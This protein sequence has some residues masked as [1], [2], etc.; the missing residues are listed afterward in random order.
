MRAT[1]SLLAL[2]ALLLAAGCGGGEAQDPPAATAEAEPTEYVFAPGDRI[3]VELTMYDGED[4][5]RTPFFS[6]YRPSIEF[7][8][9][10]PAVECGAHLPVDL[11][12]F[13]PGET[14]TIVLECGSEVAVPVDDPGFA[15]VEDGVERG[16][17]EVVPT[18]EE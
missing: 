3:T 2:G 16:T 9:G 17:G 4:G 14:H 8:H 13:P 15:L 7:G 6:G 5:R 18:G 10:G 11:R 12:E 1:P